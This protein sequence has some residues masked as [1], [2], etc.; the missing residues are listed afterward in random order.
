V[1]VL[2]PTFPRNIDREDDRLSV[3][4]HKDFA[5]KE[6]FVG[7]VDDQGTRVAHQSAQDGLSTCETHPA[8]RSMNVCAFTDH[9]RCP[10]LY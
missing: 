1:N 4:V 7:R 8:R 9:A 3:R 10:A 5:I 2:D 6:I